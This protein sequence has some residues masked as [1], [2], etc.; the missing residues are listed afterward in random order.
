MDG[1]NFGPDS[2]AATVT[3]GKV[4][5]GSYVASYT[6]SMVSS[7]GFALNHTRLQC[8]APSGIG[9][10]YVFQVNVSGQVSG[11]GSDVLSYPDPDIFSGTLRATSSG[12]AGILEYNP[13]ESN[14]TSVRGNLSIAGEY[15]EFYG[16]NFGPEFSDATVTY[17]PLTNPAKYSCARL[18]VAGTWSQSSI[19]CALSPGS[20]KDL[21]FVVTVSTGQQSRVG[22]DSFSY[23][24]PS[25]TAS[26]LRYACGS[27]SSGSNILLVEHTESSPGSTTVSVTEGP[28]NE[29]CMAGQSAINATGT[30]GGDLVRFDGNHFG[31]L[32][33][34][35]RVT[36]TRDFFPF[37]YVAEVLAEGFSETS[38]TVRTQAGL[39]RN[40]IF[41]V[42]VSGQV[43]FT[44]DVYNYPLNKSLSSENVSASTTSLFS[45]SLTTAVA[46]ISQAIYLQTK[47][48]NGTNL[49]TGGASF[50][51]DANGIENRFSVNVTDQHDGVYSVLAPFTRS[52]SYTL[53]VQLLPELLHVQGSPFTVSVVANPVVSAQLSGINMPNTVQTAGVSFAYVLLSRDVYGNEITG[54]QDLFYADARAPS[55][56]SQNQSATT[57]PSPGSRISAKWTLTVSGQYS[58]KVWYNGTELQFGFSPIF[59]F[60]GVDSP[61]NAVLLSPSSRSTDVETVVSFSLRNSDVYGNVITQGGARIVASIIQSVPV[62]LDSIKFVDV[63]SGDYT[64]LV[65]ITITGSYT[66]AVGLGDISR[67]YPFS[68]LSLDVAPGNASAPVS[69]I[70][71]IESVTAGEA[72]D[73]VIYLTD[74]YGNVVPE[75]TSSPALSLYSTVGG[76]PAFAN[77]SSAS[78]LNNSGAISYAGSI[79]TT[80]S[81]TYLLAVTHQ[82]QDFYR[83][84]FTIEIIAAAIDRTKCTAQQTLL[85]G[86]ALFKAVGEGVFAWSTG[87]VK[88]GTRNSP[89]YLIITAK[90]T[91]ENPTVN[92]Q[93]SLFTVSSSP[94]FGIIQP[95]SLGFSAYLSTITNPTSS[96]FVS[97][98]YDGVNIGPT[99]GGYTANV[100]TSQAGISATNSYLFGAPRPVAGVTSYFY[101][102]AVDTQNIPMAKGG[103]SF[104]FSLVSAP[105]DFNSTDLGQ[106]VSATDSSLGWYSV[107]FTPTRSGMYSVDVSLS[108]ASVAQSPIEILAYPASI[109]AQGSTLHGSGLTLATSGSSGEFFVQARDAYGNL[110]GYDPRFREPFEAVI[111]GGSFVM[112]PMTYFGNGTG[113]VSYHITVSG[114]YSVQV[115]TIS[116]LG[117]GLV[118]GVAK[119]LLVRPLDLNPNSSF[120]FGADSGVSCVA[121][122]PARV[123]LALRDK[124][125]NPTPNASVSLDVSVSVDQVL[126]PASANVSKEINEDQTVSILFTVTRSGSFVVSVNLGNG[127][128]VANTSLSVSASEPFAN[129]SI[130]SMLQQS[131]FRVDQVVSLQIISVDV[132]GNNISTGG[133]SFSATMSPSDPASAAIRSVVTDW[134]NGTYVAQFGTL[135]LGNYTIQVSLVGF[136]ESLPVWEAAIRVIRGFMSPITSLP[137]SL[138]GLDVQAGTPAVLNITARDSFFNPTDNRD[139][140]ITATAIPAHGSA[141]LTVFD[142]G[143]SV[144]VTLN[145]TRSG[146]YAVSVF[147]G[148]GVQLASSPF[149]F[150]ISPSAIDPSLVTF[151]GGGLTAAVAGSASSYAIEVR[152]RFGNLAP[153]SSNTIFP[154]FVMTLAQVGGSQTKNVDV[155]DSFNSSYQATY[156]ITTSGIFSLSISYSSSVVTGFPINV[157]VFPTTVDASASSV[158][159]IAPLTPAAGDTL[160]VNL[161]SRDYY[162][163]NISIGGT[164]FTVELFQIDSL[165]AQQVGVVMADGADGTYSFSSLVTKSG[166]YF[167]GVFLGDNHVFG[168][169]ARI[170]VSPGAA[171]AGASNGDGP[172]LVSGR[173][174]TRLPYSIYVRDVF[175]NNLASG[176]AGAVVATYTFPGRSAVVESLSQDVGVET[177]IFSA[178]TEDSQVGNFSV[179]ITV[180]GSSIAGS[181]FLVQLVTAVTGSPDASK[182]YAQGVGLSSATAGSP[183]SFVI[184]A[185]DSAGLLITNGGALFV[186]ELVRGAFIQVIGSTDNGDGTYGVSL[187]VTASGTYTLAINTIGVSIS[188]SPFTVDVFPS[189]TNAQSSSLSGHGLTAG[190]AGLEGSFLI[191]ARDRF[192]NVQRFFFGGSASTFGV[193]VVGPVSSTA[194][195]TSV[196]D[197]TFVAKYAATVA[198][199]YLVFITVSGTPSLGPINLRI[200]PGEPSATNSMLAGVGASSVV[201]GDIAQFRWRP[202]DA[203]GNLILASTT[204]L[205]ILN[206]SPPS[207]ASPTVANDGTGTILATYLPTVGGTY[208]LS[209]SLPGTS[210]DGTGWN[211]TI[212]A[213]VFDSSSS[214]ATGLG[215]SLDT[216]GILATFTVVARDRY[217]NLI[218]KGFTF[219]TL[220]KTADGDF[221]ASCLSTTYFCNYMVTRSGSLTVSV[222]KGAN[223]VSGSPF[224]VKVN[225]SYVD[226][227]KSAT[228]ATS[229]A[230]A[231]QDNT[232]FI[233]LKDR[234]ENQLTDGGRLFSVKLSGRDIIVVPPNSISDGGDGT[235][236]VSYFASVSGS[237]SLAILSQSL[238]IAQSPINMTISSGLPSPAVSSLLFQQLVSCG[239]SLCGTVDAKHDMV[240]SLRDAYNNPVDANTYDL[241]LSTEVDGLRRYG[242]VSKSSQLGDFVGFFSATVSGTYK[243][244]V[245]VAAVEVGGSPLTA[246]IASGKLIDSGSILLSGSS[247]T[248]ATAGSNVPFTMQARDVFSN[249]VFEPTFASAVVA[250]VGPEGNLVSIGSNLTRSGTEKVSVDLTITRSGAYILSLTLLAIN[251]V[252]TPLILR[253]RP[254]PIHAPSSDASGSGAKG[255]EQN[256]QATIIVTPRD[257]FGNVAAF[258]GSLFQ[259]LKGN[260]LYPGRQ[261]EPMQ[262]FLQSTSSFPYELPSSSEISSTFAL[263]YFPRSASAGVYAE[264]TID[265]VGIKDS[266]I[267][268]TISFG[269][270]I[271]TATS[272]SFATG[273]GISSSTAGSPASFTIQA[274][275]ASGL[276]LST[277]GAKFTASTTFVNSFRSLTVTDKENGEY[278]VT[279]DVTASGTYTLTCMISSSHIVG[280]PFSVRVFP[281][282]TS[283]LASSISGVGMSSATAGVEGFFLVQ[284]RDSFYNVQRYFFGDGSSLF[285]FSLKGPSSKSAIGFSALRDS[286]YVVT[287]N[288]TTSGT[289]TASLKATGDPTPRTWTF[290]VEPS[291]I[292]ITQCRIS[293]S[294]L[295]KEHVAGANLH[296]KIMARDGL[297]NLVAAP[298][299]QGGLT[300]FQ[301]YVRP[302]T[303]ATIKSVDGSFTVVANVTCS[304]SY[305]L[306]VFIAAGI[307]PGSPYSFRVMPSRLS[308]A[309]TRVSGEALGGG[310]AGVGLTIIIYP[311][312]SFGN[313]VELSSDSQLQLSLDGRGTAASVSVSSIVKQSGRIIAQYV[314]SRPCS[315]CLLSVVVQ[316]QHVS[317]SPFEADFVPSDP[318]RI[319]Q[320]IFNF[321]LTAADVT[322]DVPTNRHGK[323]GSIFSCD[324]AFDAAT[325]AAAGDGP[326]CLWSSGTV[327][328][329][330]FGS[331]SQLLPGSSLVLARGTSLQNAFENSFNSTGSAVLRLPSQIQAPS[332]VIM[333]PATVGA[334]DAL[335]LDASQSTG[336][337]GRTLRFLWGLELGPSN[338]ESIVT[339]FSILDPASDSITLAPA[340][341][342]QGE[343][344]NFSLIL[345]DVFGQR[346]AAYHRV[347]ATALPTPVVS[348]VSIPTKKLSRSLALTLNGQISLPSC[349]SSTSADLFWESVGGPIFPIRERTRR[350]ST[351]SV[352]ANTLVAGGTYTVRLIGSFASSA[353]SFADVSFTV[354]NTPL[355]AA[356]RG[357]DR[358][359]SASQPLVLDASVSVDPDDEPGSPSY[360]WQCSPSPCFADAQNILLESG[361][362]L[363]VPP[364]QL[365]VDA[366]YTFTVSFFKDP[367]PRQASATALISVVA[368]NVAQV[369]FAMLQGARAKVNSVDRL[370]LVGSVT[371]PSGE[372]QASYSWRS[373]DGLFPIAN[374]SVRTTDITSPNLVLVGGSLVRGSTYTFELRGTCVGT[375]EEG[376]SRMAIVVNSPPVGGTFV[377]SPPTGS[378]AQTLFKLACSGWVDDA[379]DLPISYQ[380][381]ALR[382]SVVGARQQPL[383]RRVLMNK[384][385]VLLPGP[386]EGGSP[387]SVSLSVQV[388]DS[389]GECTSL[390]DRIVTVVAPT[391]PSSQLID[392]ALSAALGVGNIDSIFQLGTSV[393]LLL[394]QAAAGDDVSQRSKLVGAFNDASHTVDLSPDMLSIM[395]YGLDAV[396]DSPTQKLTAMHDTS[397]ALLASLANAA[398]TAGINGSAASSILG[399]LSGLSR[400]ADLGLETNTSRR[401]LTPGQVFDRISDVSRNVGRSLLVGRVSYESRVTVSNGDL[402]QTVWRLAKAQVGGSKELSYPCD[403][404][405]PCTAVRMPLQWTWRPS[406]LDTQVLS[407]GPRLRHVEAGTFLSA[408]ITTV[409]AMDGA[410]VVEGKLGD[411]FPLFVDLYVSPSTVAGSTGAAEDDK[412][413]TCEY[414]NATL[415]RWSKWGCIAF[416]SNASLISCACYHL[417]DFTSLI[418]PTAQL[419]TLTIVLPVDKDLFSP[420][421]Q[422]GFGAAVVGFTA[423]GT[424]LL[425]LLA[426]LFDRFQ[427]RRFQPDLATELLGP[428]GGYVQAIG[429]GKV[430]KNRFGLFLGLLGGTVAHLMKRR[431]GIVS[432][433]FWTPRDPYT[434]TPRVVALLLHVGSCMVLSI[435]LMSYAGFTDS[436]S[437]SC[438]IITSIILLPLHPILT[439]S[440]RSIAPRKFKDRGEQYARKRPFTAEG[441]NPVQMVQ[442]VILEDEAQRMDAEERAKA[443]ARSDLKASRKEDED[444][445][446]D[447]DVD[448]N[449][450]KG[451]GTGLRREA[452][453]EPNSISVDAGDLEARSLKPDELS[454]LDS[455]H[456]SRVKGQGRDDPAP[457]SVS[458]AEEIRR[459]MGSRDEEGE[460]WGV[461]QAFGAWVSG[462]SFGGGYVP[463][464]R[465]E[466]Q[467]PDLDIQDDFL[468]PRRPPEPSATETSAGGRTTSQPTPAPTLERLNT[469]KL[470]DESRSAMDGD[471]GV[472][473][474]RPR[475]LPPIKKWVLK[476]DKSVM[477]IP[478][479]DNAK[480]GRPFSAGMLSPFRNAVVPEGQS[481]DGSRSGDGSHGDD[482]HAQ[483]LPRVLFVAVYLASALYYLECALICS[484][485]SFDMSESTKS[486]WVTSII[487]A[488]F[489]HFVIVEPLAYLTYGFVTIRKRLVDAAMG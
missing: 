106:L 469:E 355:V 52:G 194:T 40:H 344:Y 447:E 317:G 213:N 319:T 441:E 404:G 68:P 81:G 37:T 244:S 63:G 207:I 6:C 241:V 337:G 150:I 149:N 481:S 408:P 120:I 468:A 384:V 251:A 419:P 349:G 262:V 205:P 406:I 9:T 488:V 362:L 169:P 334:C 271:R 330:I 235:Y 475:A 430:K 343:T 155:T 186:S 402:R 36:Y 13:S 10:G 93:T 183:A 232:F 323:L 455:M 192:S 285:S 126:I 206:F 484:L 239:S 62:D 423:I 236:A 417:S 224:P 405:L 338:R 14:A 412:I 398:T 105:A 211:V 378:S 130:V 12:A 335:T 482:R 203:F 269:G 162:G 407:W 424:I 318:P 460:Y 354:E 61:N 181:P 187:D 33:S 109:S 147:A 411:G 11:A 348:I 69:A 261:P 438:G 5:G 283:A 365:S 47:D 234:Y 144:I 44:S 104:E 214:T 230:T 457:P 137:V 178:Y 170:S 415:G 25:T 159:Q 434:R 18:S 385:H 387:H 322:F 77:D 266:P 2:L 442:G 166:D 476:T 360:T 426:H 103:S 91:Y 435:L 174:N 304:G 90:D 359:V 324:I 85:T 248:L 350:S 291:A 420:R 293:A 35:V 176:Y 111:L 184:Q 154:P 414:W 252:G 377:V 175:G 227:D 133:A 204:T 443:K 260:L 300:N 80:K 372:C 452:A 16:R 82:S 94:S 23:P 141:F 487:W 160:A 275:D 331:G 32:A 67:T 96:M 480:S 243:I 3:L 450:E 196:R 308:V 152:D 212:G 219:T 389:V 27:G 436:Q 223:H 316:G 26:S 57:E 217:S 102:Q 463:P 370:V 189:V 15:V 284:A 459:R 413:A 124:Y 200:Y 193:S 97:I 140:S 253:V 287:Y 8:I 272:N 403:G 451:E 465:A 98:K 458:K 431:H 21:I 51:V 345:S 421:G 163:N 127:T 277:G 327:L 185:V 326:K 276:W 198:G 164:N 428:E 258:Q 158:T 180:A 286:S 367:G 273:Q 373:W 210:V 172:G 347:T 325:T 309:T 388:C 310:K 270:G 328:S 329:L 54:I 290:Q 353:A 379:T 439:A 366:N 464:S 1:T 312:D 182:C 146:E 295:A 75:Q 282:A 238:P 49:L 7:G 171:N 478:S 471:G 135:R 45:A 444:E 369:S 440:F 202:S 226:T 429:V 383:T 78:F 437:I 209:V 56:I 24:P 60:P 445:D 117:Y 351:I 108:A 48:L 165:A 222:L 453:L 119:T 30:G 31:P 274:A 265:G 89:F 375:T 305:S 114:E 29:T 66:I 92:T 55:L 231:G 233:V 352:A 218:T 288:V 72:K 381:S 332:P 110:L 466:M 422:E 242:F 410:N 281:G 190:T 259:T 486:S 118:G 263:I 215:V 313:T 473:Q 84:P 246:Y 268:V 142:V 43:G 356:I 201:A 371:S 368:D 394:N 195:M 4:M 393:A 50:L 100:F 199:N 74:K 396:L 401:V 116:S 128:F 278:A 88:G 59:L 358:T 216:A 477:K 131:P 121:G 363:I 191:Q 474:E 221:R 395:A 148:S 449:M 220:V 489:F 425:A 228:L 87:P 129:N 257:R 151:S 433:I 314:A 134:G 237:Y 297:G 161:Q 225:P 303:P 311:R 255:S 34:D 264:V 46:G 42:S 157:T 294:D 432:I 143:S 139:G 280:S 380:F 22:L 122:S 302:D 240:I 83:S 249:S 53:S 64:I 76:V 390:S 448:G 306:S 483:K 307:I 245:S 229:L 301:A 39:G 179:E 418:R 279:L 361:P 113:S 38:I 336:G 28:A 125:N 267:P 461:G 292:E 173:I 19:R 256:K 315:S 391:L 416:N 386:S 123:I 374:S 399:G 73:V 341:I 138:Q 479:V 392:V 101:I 197:S 339:G 299:V 364:S 485:H 71:A 454:G 333:G 320:A 112:A 321:L 298:A 289:Y 41:A 86:D 168:S 99:A 400:S 58:I 188:G 177:A 340:T 470:P 397:L 254:G 342:L 472:T 156:L 296:F 427:V 115:R 79:Y 70:A 107:A 95:T 382:V 167:M 446:E 17:G 250:A 132:Y 357:G 467:L 20:G 376:V 346:V 145:T 65:R 456:H 208:R 462:G 409:L 136:P 247:L 153:G